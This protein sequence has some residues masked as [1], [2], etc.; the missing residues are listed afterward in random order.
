MT[1]QYPFY[2]AGEWE[3]ST[4]QL[5]VTNPYDDSVVAATWLA[6]DAD[7]ERA[8][9]GAVEAAPTMRRLPAYRRAE[10]LAQASAVL[11]RRRDEIGRA[12]AG[13][14]GKPIRDALTEVDR[15]AMTF[16]VASEEARRLGG[17]VIPLDLA[18]HG[19][20]RTAILRRVPLGPVSGISPFNFPLNLSAH[21][22]APAIAA[23]NTMVLKPASKTPLSALFLASA[24]DEAGLPK[25][26]LSVLP[27]SRELGDRLVTDDRFKLLTFTGSSPVGWAMKARAGKKKVLLELGGNAGVIVDAS[28]NLAY[29]ARRVVTGGFAYAGQSCISVQRV[30]VHA[31]VYDAFVTLLIEKLSGLVIGDPLDPATDLGPMIDAGEV[32]RIEAWVKEAVAQG[33][34]VLTGGSPISRSI[35]APTVLEQVP[36]RSRICAQEVFA[37]VIGL[38]RFTDFNDAMAAVNRSSFGLQAGVF[39][40]DLLHTLAAYDTLEAGGIIVNDVPTWRIDHMPY[41]GVKDSG[42]GREGPR[43]AIE[44]MTEPRLLVINREMA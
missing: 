9:A 1:H 41:G 42:T 31:D 20:G 43:Y 39:T 38:Y 18:A 36:E 29:A 11:I 34:R 8:T 2:L 26:A 13:E 12:L 28:A 44:E 23:G 17:E 16:H 7:V 21:K 33:A 25:G 30:F 5:A 6:A 27:M 15:A 14:A 35:F 4:H 37:P 3:T 19:Q 24:L 32:D 10:I 22:I 40:N